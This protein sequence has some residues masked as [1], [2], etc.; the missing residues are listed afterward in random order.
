MRKS[1]PPFLTIWQ[2]LVLAICMTTWLAELYYNG[3]MLVFLD[4]SGDTGRKVDAGS[5][6][7]FLVGLV[8]FDDDAEALRCDNRISCLRKEINRPNNFEFHFSNNSHNVRTAFL[9]A[10]QQYNFKCVIVAIDKASANLNRSIFK[11]KAS[12]YQWACCMVIDD[13]LPNLF[14]A[15]FVID[16]SGNSTFQGQ[17]RRYI[18]NQTNS[19]GRDKIKKFKMQDSQSNNLLQLADYCVGV[20]NCRIQ[21]KKDWQEYYKYIAKKE[22]SY[23]IWS[24]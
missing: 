23:R 7:Y 8:L 12:F 15:K 4:E 1:Q 10:A 3:K 11:D 17:L 18:R 14:E 22:L 16:K 21:D 24:K 2:R 6:N 20:Y 5:S 19:K 13:V 9:S